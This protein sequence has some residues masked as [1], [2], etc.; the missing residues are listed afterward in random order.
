MAIHHKQKR[1]ESGVAKEKVSQQTEALPANQTREPGKAQ[2]QRQMEEA[3]Q[4][5]SQTVE[6]IKDT[7]E[8]QYESVK[9]TVSG[10][11]DF[12]EQFQND[13]IVWSVGALSA[14]FALGY[15][16]GYAHKNLESSG[17]K[18][19]EVAA[20]ADSLVDELAKVGNSLVM[21]TLNE[22]IKQLFGFDFS[23]MLEEISDAKKPASRKR[24]PRKSSPKKR[25]SMKRP[26]TKG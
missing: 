22:K 17:R 20:F 18:R 24:S 16:L 21:P 9:K 11:L 26:T 12:R 13:P 14:G 8:E 19:S 4:S 5:I 6:E 3:R 2:L 1:K 15:T 23:D 7:V 10:V 25:A